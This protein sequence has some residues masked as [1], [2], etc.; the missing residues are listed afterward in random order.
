MALDAHRFHLYQ[1]L[2]EYDLASSQLEKIEEIVHS[3]L[4]QVPYI[5]NLRSMNGLNDISIAGIF[6]EAR[7]NFNRLPIATVS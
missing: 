3:V 2:E 5:E 1:L 6:G 7:D 4:D